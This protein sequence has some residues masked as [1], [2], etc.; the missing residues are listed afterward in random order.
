MLGA[1][2]AFF[3]E[4]DFIEVDTPLAVRSPG[5]DL[6]IEAHAVPSLGWLITSPEYAM[7][8]LLAEGLERI[9]Q[10]GH[11]F[12]RD[13]HGQHHEPEFCMLEWYRANA[14]SEEMITDTEALVETLA[15]ELRG[16][17][18]LDVV[19]TDGSSRTIDVQPPFARL[20]VDEA[21]RRFAAVEL[22]AVL[23]DEE[24]F[25]RLWI[26]AVEPAL[27]ELGAVFITHWP[28]SMASL[29]RLHP[30]EPAFADRFELYLGGVEI[31]NG[32]GELV[33]PIEQRARLRRDA[34]LRR[35]AGLEAYPIDERFLAALQAGIPPSGGNALG[36]DRLLML[37]L[38]ASTVGDVMPFDHERR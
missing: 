3:A 28:A 2:R 6:H 29:A 20:R 33:D 35:Q 11:V 13:E 36:V 32:F 22:D 14:G 34:E 5:L 30:D 31:C 37:L 1:I 26:D 18:S 10:L 23:P 21:L 25:Y 19:D 15:L 9:F 17:R 12:R 24:R 16:S 7:K 38:G 4:R 27:K 8:R